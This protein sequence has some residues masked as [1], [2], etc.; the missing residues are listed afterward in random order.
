MR[1]NW[2]P[3]NL[4][5]SKEPVIGQ[6]TTRVAPYVSLTDE[7]VAGIA[8]IENDDIATKYWDEERNLDCNCIRSCT[9]SG[10]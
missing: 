3:L 2:K 10:S 7:Y 9:F 5:R 4:T 8:Q 1:I 6:F